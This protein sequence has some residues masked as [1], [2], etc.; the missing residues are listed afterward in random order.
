MKVLNHQLFPFSILWAKNPDIK[1]AVLNGITTGS[2]IGL[3][4]SIIM[5]V[6]NSL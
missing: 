6:T 2:L 4:V 5:I 1:Y 3:I